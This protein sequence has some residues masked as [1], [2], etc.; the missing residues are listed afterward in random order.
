MKGDVIVNDAT[1]ENSAVLIVGNDQVSAPKPIDIAPTISDVIHSTTSHVS[2]NSTTEKL[3][4]KSQNPIIISSVIASGLL[5]VLLIFCIIIR[6]YL[7]RR[8]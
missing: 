4:A 3:N 8:A 7:K 1:F 5:I 2:P 6:P